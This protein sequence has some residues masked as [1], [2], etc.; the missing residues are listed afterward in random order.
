MN[1]GLFTDTYSPQLNGVVTVVRSLEEELIKKGHNVYI[2]T[3]ETP[4]YAD[5]KENVYRLPSIKFFWEPNL[6]LAFPYYFAPLKKA[7]KW[8]LDLVHSHTPFTLGKIA[9]FIAKKM[10][11][12]EIHTYHTMYEEYAN[13]YLPLPT[14]FLKFYAKSE[15]K[16]FCDRT[17]A[18]V[19][20]SKKIKKVLLGYD[21][22]KPIVVLP[23]G[24]NLDP[25]LYHK[26]SK[27]EIEAFKERWGLLGYKTIIFVGRM[28]DEKNIDVLLMNFKKV[29]KKLNDTKLLMVG[30]GPKIKKYKELSKMLKIS[31]KVVFTG[32][33]K[34]WPKE[35][36]IAYHS[37]DVFATASHTE[38]HPMTFIEAMAS[39]LPVVAS[40]DGSVSD[41]VDG[42][43]YLF[44]DDR[45]LY[46]GLIKIL[47]NSDLRDEMSRRSSEISEIYSVDNFINNSLKLYKM[48]LNGRVNLESFHNNTGL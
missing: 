35:L 8:K 48:A 17:T 39:S 37:A 43:G 15:S 18:V 1:I 5:N 7:K 2:F 36:S 31:D 12:P 33:L 3:V 38:V 44:E 29:V 11:I 20:P 40:Y 41:M 27:S 19:A 47:S 23:N 25:F 34:N 14:Q 10:K 21:I 6:R 22:K 4:G 30:N 9:H 32:F 16:R 42:N 24:I 26:P 13:I 45:K 46:E 28:A